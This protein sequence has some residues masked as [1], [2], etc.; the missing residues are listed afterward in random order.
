MPDGSS[1]ALAPR[2]RRQQIGASEGGDQLLKYA[3]PASAQIAAL[4]QNLQK[5]EGDPSQSDTEVGK[6]TT[7]T[8]PGLAIE[9]VRKLRE[10]KY[11]EELFNMLSRQDEA[12]RMDEA[13]ESPAVE[14]IDAEEALEATVA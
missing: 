13:K 5:V 11:H 7:S 4:K 6:L 8:V 12:A 10:V 3:R 2:R 9:Y 1:T 14:V